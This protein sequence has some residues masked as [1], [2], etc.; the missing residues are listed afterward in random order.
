MNNL[1]PFHNGLENYHAMARQ[2]A[3]RALQGAM[4]RRHECSA[5]AAYYRS[6][7]RD[8]IAALRCLRAMGA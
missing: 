2:G 5:S 8:A 4:A 6:Y 7:A 1:L 3:I